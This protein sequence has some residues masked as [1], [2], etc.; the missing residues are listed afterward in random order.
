MF[1]LRIVLKF[2]TL[3]I[4]FTISE[5]RD[6]NFFKFERKK[7]CINFYFFFSARRKPVCRKSN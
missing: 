3:F 4:S 7:H 5:C 1:V 6:N 2:G